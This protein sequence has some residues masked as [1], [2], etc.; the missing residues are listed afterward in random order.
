LEL[1]LTKPKVKLPRAI[2]DVVG[3]LRPKPEPFPDFSGKLPYRPDPKRKTFKKMPFDLPDDEARYEGRFDVKRV[4]NRRSDMD[5]IK[6]S[7]RTEDLVYK[8]PDWL[9]KILDEPAQDVQARMV[10]RQKVMDQLGSEA[11]KPGAPVK[12]IQGLMKTRSGANVGNINKNKQLNTI[13]Q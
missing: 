6:H 13:D 11:K 1:A 2:I 8:Q 12:K 5:T 10:R 4:G 9:S 3:K 7:K